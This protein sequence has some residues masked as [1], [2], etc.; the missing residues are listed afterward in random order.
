MLTGIPLDRVPLWGLFAATVVLFLLC[1]EIGFQLGER[2]P[3]SSE[4]LQRSQAGTIMGTTF[5]L[6]AFIL[7]FTFGAA[8]SRFEARKQ[9]V[10]DEANA[11]GTTYLRAD[12]LPEPERAKI[13]KLLGEYVD[14]R[15][16]GVQY[17]REGQSEK[18]AQEV[19][20]SEE[21]QA[22]LWS[23][24][25]PLAEKGASP[26]LAGLF[27]Q[28]LNELIDIHSKRLTTGLLNRIPRTIWIA[29]Y[30]VG[31]LSMA[32]MGYHAGLSG[33]RSLLASLVLAL[34]FFAVMLLIADLDRPGQSLFSVNQQV[35]ID[36]R[37]K[38]N[39]LE[40]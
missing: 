9:L 28:S 40:P 35:M 15:L 14:S 22:R 23:L 27:V 38:V 4:E 11:I 12:F 37:N 16:R 8:A 29:L 36:L 26:V 19:A 5:A 30:F 7:A 6:L 1:I 33:M 2:K 21:L 13:R 34:T 10:L 20:R 24:A 17:M 25:A 31:I 18:L 32:V 3:R 39:T